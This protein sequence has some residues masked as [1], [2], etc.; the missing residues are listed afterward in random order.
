M[1]AFANFRTLVLAR[2]STML[3]TSPSGTVL[4]MTATIISL[5]LSCPKSWRATNH[6]PSSCS[7]VQI[8][9][10]EIG[11]VAST[12]PSRAMPSVWSLWRNT[13]CHWCFLA[14][15]VTPSGMWPDVGPTRLPYV[16]VKIWQLSYLSIQSILNTLLRISHCFRIPIRARKMPIPDSIWI[17]SWKPCIINSKWFNM[18]PQYKYV[19]KRKLFS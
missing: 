19:F 17:P 13:I 6:P 11:S 2:G 1:N 4:T 7:V 10:Q 15:V 18:R 5:F 14:A 9:C 8:H 3:S 12:L 16:P